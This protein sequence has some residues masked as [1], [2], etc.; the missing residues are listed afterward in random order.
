LELLLRGTKTA[1]PICYKRMSCINYHAKIVERPRTDLQ[2]LENSDFRTQKSHSQK[3]DHTC[4]Y[5]W[6]NL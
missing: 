4:G 5:H 1:Y 6:T 3:Y 2:N